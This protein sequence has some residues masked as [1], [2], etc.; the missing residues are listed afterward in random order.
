M[1]EQDC[2][3][4]SGFPPPELAGLFFSKVARQPTFPYAF[5]GFFPGGHHKGAEEAA[6]KPSILTGTGG[7]GD[8]V[9]EGDDERLVMA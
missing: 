2:G 8:S 6:R 7:T 5:P 9:S 1:T 3:T 4:K